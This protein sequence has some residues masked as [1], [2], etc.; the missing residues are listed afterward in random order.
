M[1]PPL[2]DVQYTTFIDPPAVRRRVNI[3]K[4]GGDVDWFV[5]QLEYNATVMGQT[6][7][8]K[9]VARF[10]HHPQYSWGHDVR[11]EGLHLD[12]YRNGRKYK[13]ITS[14]FPQLPVNEYPAYCE[15]YFKKQWHALIERFEQWNGFSYYSSLP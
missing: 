5:V 14:G 10:D 9:Q 15:E 11:I 4:T 2:P 3:G 7:D 12:L 1:H 6:N 8:W 13:V